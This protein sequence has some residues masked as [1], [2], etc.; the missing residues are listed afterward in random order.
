MDISDTGQLFAIY[1]I[2]GPLSP[3][4]HTCPAHTRASDGPAVFPGR[5]ILQVEDACDFPLPYEA[6]VASRLKLT[7]R[8]L[9]HLSQAGASAE[10][11]GASDKQSESLR[12][13]VSLQTCGEQIIKQTPRKKW[14]EDEPE[15]TS[16]LE[17]VVATMEPIPLYDILA[18]GYLPAFRAINMVDRGHAADDPH[19]KAV[20]PRVRLSNT[21]NLI[22]DR[23]SNLPGVI[24]LKPG[25]MRDSGFWNAGAPNLVV[26][27][28]DRRSHAQEL[29][30][31]ARW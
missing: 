31:R 30:A 15:P 11:A 4:M 25:A 19:T 13:V 17:T 27:V 20:R 21:M 18:T 16:A 8:T 12:V 10:D 2:E 24:V 9:S 22:F 1:G 3:Q 6:I 29:M 23:A 5:A 14:E 28:G 7:V 26:L